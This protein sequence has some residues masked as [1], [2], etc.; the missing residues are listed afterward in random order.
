MTTL[1]ARALLGQL[2]WATLGWSLLGAA[3]FAYGAR[4]V[5]LVA[6]GHYTSAGG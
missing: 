5:W 3:L 1:P 2:R 4:R 6:V